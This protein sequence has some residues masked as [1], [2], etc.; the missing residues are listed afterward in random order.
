M[1]VGVP[2]SRIPTWLSTS[3]SSSIVVP[4]GP[5]GVTGCTCQVVGPLWAQGLGKKVYAFWTA[6]ETS[7]IRRILIGDPVCLCGLALSDVE[8]FA[9]IRLLQIFHTGDDY[10]SSCAKKDPS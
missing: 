8:G 3:A 4:L 1:Q 6:P 7:Q 9:L 5:I 10:R 2:S